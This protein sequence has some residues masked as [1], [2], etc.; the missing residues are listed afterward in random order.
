MTASYTN[1]EAA[2]LTVNRVDDLWLVVSSE[3]FSALRFN[4]GYG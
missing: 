2:Y 1:P 3:G 4:R